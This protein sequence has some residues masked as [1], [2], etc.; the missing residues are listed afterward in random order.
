MM[1]EGSTEYSNKRERQHQS[2]RRPPVR[3]NWRKRRAPSSLVENTE[4]NRLPNENT[5]LFYSLS[6]NKI[7]VYALDND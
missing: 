3:R 4:V 5:I 1:S 2:K 6:E 7:S